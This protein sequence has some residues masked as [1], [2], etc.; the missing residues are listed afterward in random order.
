MGITTLVLA[1][2]EIYMRF[3]SFLQRLRH[4]RQP[5]PPET[6]TEQRTP[7]LPPIKFRLSRN[8]GP[9]APKYQSCPECGKG[10]KRIFKRGSNPPYPAVASYECRHCKLSKSSVGWDVPLKEA[11]PFSI[12]PR[13]LLPWG[14]KKLPTT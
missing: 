6:G 8:P 10:C 9:N 5:A 4:G 7:E 2:L 14:K 1:I 13:K 11:Y 12:N 3:K